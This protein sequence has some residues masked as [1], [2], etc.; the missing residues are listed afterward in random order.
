VRK[1][2]GMLYQS[3]NETEWLL[4]K[5]GLAI[6]LC[7][8]LLHHKPKISNDNKV[9][10]LLQISNEIIRQDIA[11]E[12]LDQLYKLDQSVFGDPNW[13]D[14]FTIMDP[15]KIKIE[16]LNLTDSL[17]AFIIG[18]I[19]ISKVLSDYSHFEEQIAYYFE[20]RVLHGCMQGKIKS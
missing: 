9:D 12:L 1:D 3:V 2:F 14:I 17:E 18:I 5:S 20:N 6:L 7:I 4:F 10:F 19:K 11:N 13:T 8:E 15:T 16:H